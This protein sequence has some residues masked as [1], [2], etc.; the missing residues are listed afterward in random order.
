MALNVSSVVHL[1]RESQQAL[2]ISLE[3][4]ASNDE[5]AQIISVDVDRS[6]W[7]LW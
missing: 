6:V 5:T 4:L 2:R 3:E 7:R 1:L